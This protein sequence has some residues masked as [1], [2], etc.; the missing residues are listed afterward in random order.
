L[1]VRLL[2][3]RKLRLQALKGL[4][5]NVCDLPNQ[6]AQISPAFE[7]QQLTTIDR[8]QVGESGQ[9]TS[10]QSRLNRAVLTNGRGQPIS[11]ADGAHAV[12]RCPREFPDETSVR[13]TPTTISL[14]H[15]EEIYDVVAV[16]SDLGKALETLRK[17]CLDSA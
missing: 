17:A 15:I 2:G 9:V 11:F 14:V 12:E 7:R 3:L 5:L 8:H 13:P 6:V 1:L 10:N 4:C 16:A